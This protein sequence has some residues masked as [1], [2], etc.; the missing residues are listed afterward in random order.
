MRMALKDLLEDLGNGIWQSRR[1]PHPDYIQRPTTP[2]HLV[3][4]HRA[5]EGGG[6]KEAASSSFS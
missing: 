6:W 3:L 1:G 2:A 4:M 5:L